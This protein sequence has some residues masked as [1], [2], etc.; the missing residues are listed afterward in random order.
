MIYEVV[1]VNSATAA[2][3]VGCFLDDSPERTSSKAAPLSSSIIDDDDEDAAADDDDDNNL[4][5]VVTV[6][7]G[8]PSQ[9]LL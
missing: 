6:T 2:A 9:G 8:V 1:G 3:R 4:F 7:G 5:S